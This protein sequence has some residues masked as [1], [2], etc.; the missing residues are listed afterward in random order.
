[1]LADTHA[2]VIGIVCDEP[3]PSHIVSFSVR[4]DAVLTSEDHVRIV[5]GPFG[6][7]RSG[8]VFAV[9]PSGARYDGLINPGGESDNPDWDGIWEAATARLDTGW[10]AEIRIP[11]QTLTFKPGLHEWQFNVQRRIQRRLAGIK[12]YVLARLAEV[13]TQHNLMNKFPDQYWA[14]RAQTKEH[15]TKRPQSQIRQ[16]TYDGDDGA[17]GHLDGDVVER[18]GRPEAHR[19]RTHRVRH[20]VPTVLALPP[21]AAGSANSPNAS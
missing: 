5:L 8:Y 1:V 2:L 19:G 4:R 12:P 21:A 7:G 13:A 9:N 18:H 15:I 17:C 20:A 6:D 3:D 10:S 11:V 14:Y 16:A